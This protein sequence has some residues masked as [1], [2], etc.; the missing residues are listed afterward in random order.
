[1]RIR[2]DL[3]VAHACFSLTPQESK[4]I[5]PVV[6]ALNFSKGYFP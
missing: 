5:F 6:D 4:L 2:S 1:M 3:R